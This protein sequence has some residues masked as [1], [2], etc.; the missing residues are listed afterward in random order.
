MA[1]PTLLACVNRSTRLHAAVAATG[2]FAASYLAEDQAAIA[3]IF[4]TPDSLDRFREGAW[5]SAHA[6]PIWGAPAHLGCELTASFEAETHSILVGTVVF[7]RLFPLSL[8][9]HCNGAYANCLPSCR[10][11]APLLS[12]N[13]PSDNARRNAARG[14]KHRNSYCH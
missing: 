3:V 8:L 10:K 13:Q 7:T 6:V 14:T 5:T 12:E 2:R 4:G 1:P 11:P 9:L